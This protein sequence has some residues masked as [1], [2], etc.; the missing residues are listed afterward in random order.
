MYCNPTGTHITE[1]KNATAELAS[2]LK[3]GHRDKLKEGNGAKLK[4]NASKLK[5]EADKAH[6]KE[7]KTEMVLMQP[8]CLV[9]WAKYH[10]A[11]S[12]TTATISLATILV[13]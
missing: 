3:E 5:E 8:M 10:R 12:R 2:S 6:R 7:K 11:I 13:S 4:E 9:M 1:K